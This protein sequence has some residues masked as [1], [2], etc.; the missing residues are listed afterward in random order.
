MGATPPDIDKAITA[1]TSPNQLQMSIECGLE[2]RPTLWDS[3]ADLGKV[4]LLHLDQ[5]RG[6]QFNDIISLRATEGGHLG[7]VKWYY[8]AVKW[9]YEKPFPWHPKV[10]SAAI[11]AGHADIAEWVMDHG[12]MGDELTCQAAAWE[13][14]L[15][16]LQRA[17]AE[18]CPWDEEACSAVA[19][20]G[21]LAVLQ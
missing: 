12:G 10:V 16:L 3:A 21:H 20:R 7:T 18:G 9:C 2:I 6:Y 13:G 11:K 19:W 14:H 8:E 4:E 5:E 1:D 15:G 17:K